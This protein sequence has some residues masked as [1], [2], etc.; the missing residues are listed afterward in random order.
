MSAKVLMDVGE[1]W[2]E[3]NKVNQL[4]SS[5]WFWEPIWP[6]GKLR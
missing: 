2:N 4:R 1:Y 5:P 3:V 6:H